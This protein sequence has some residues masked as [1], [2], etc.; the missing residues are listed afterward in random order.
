MEQRLK[1]SF[2]LNLSQEASLS[3]ASGGPDG[4]SN[5]FVHRGHRKADVPGGILALRQIANALIDKR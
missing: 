2:R 3:T 5:L 4:P 1:M